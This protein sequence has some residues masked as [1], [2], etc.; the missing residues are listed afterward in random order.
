MDLK[1]L[2]TAL[3]RLVPEGAMRISDRTQNGGTLLI[4]STNAD[5]LFFAMKRALESQLDLAPDQDQEHEIIAND[6]SI[7]RTLSFNPIVYESLVDL[8][9]NR[10]AINNLI[11]T[12]QRNFF[13]EFV[14]SVRTETNQLA[15]TMEFSDGVEEYAQQIEELIVRVGQEGRQAR[16]PVE[17]RGMCERFMGDYSNLV[18]DIKAFQFVEPEEP[19]PNLPRSPG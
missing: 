5:P 13:K 10:Q 7:R 16:T 14:L 9:D 15:R 12:V 1:N 8:S 18:R 17:F 3:Q 19:P 2:V 4:S 11:A 6:E